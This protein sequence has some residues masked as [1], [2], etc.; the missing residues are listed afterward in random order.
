MDGQE[1]QEVSAQS[2]D[3]LGEPVFMKRGS[4]GKSSFDTSV[5]TLKKIRF[6]PV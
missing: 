4:V 6:G 5:C 1:F 3:V 2:K